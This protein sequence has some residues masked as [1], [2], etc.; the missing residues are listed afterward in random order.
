MIWLYSFLALTVTGHLLSACYLYS[1]SKDP[2]WALKGIFLG[3]I[4]VYFY[5]KKECSGS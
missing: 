1:K 5:N 2:S 3:L 4:A